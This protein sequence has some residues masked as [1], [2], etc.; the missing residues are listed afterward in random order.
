[1]K[2][3]S[4][5]ILKEFA[6]QYKLDWRLLAAILMK[7]SNQEGF[8][9]KKQIKTR[10]ERHILSGFRDVLLDIKKRHPSLPGLK[11]EWI[12]KH[13]PE[14]L[15]MLSTSYGM[16]QI[17]GYWYDLLEYE[18]IK[19]M[20]DAWTASEE[21]QI[22]DFCLF[23]VRFNDG[24]FLNALIKQNLQSIAMQYNGKGYAQNSYDK[25]LQIYMQKQK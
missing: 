7:E 1:M 11:A 14:E 10:L 22:R 6:N 15:N 25:D 8:N 2:D 18:T 20:I 24:R 16:A 5:E 23:C 4:K 19:D 3:K 9:N 17:M 13:S 12:K 21:I